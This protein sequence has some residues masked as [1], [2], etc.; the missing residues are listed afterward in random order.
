M[1]DEP[2]EA[3]PEA[4]PYSVTREIALKALDR[5]AY[6]RVE[7]GQY[8]A[9]KGAAEDVI[10]QV[11]ER[12]ES[13]GLIDDD[14]FAAQ[15]VDSRH[16]GRKL[17]RRALVAEL[18]RKGLDEEVIADAVAPIDGEAEWEAARQ[19]AR[20]KARGL[21]HQPDEVVLRRLVGVLGRRGFSSSMAWSVARE[22]VSDRG[23][24]GEQFEDC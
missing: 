13:V 8:L 24:S 17:P 20:T 2:D 22:V 18:R 21:Q 15:W 10:E 23:S 12:F 6:G 11:L 9:R 7:L 16:R 14:A 4:D 19:L 1:S 5:R 3:T